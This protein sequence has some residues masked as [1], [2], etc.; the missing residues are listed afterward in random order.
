MIAKLGRSKHFA[1]A[2][3]IVIAIIVYGSLYPFAFRPAD[4]GIGPALR[5]LWESRADQPGRITFIG[6]ILLYMPLGFFAIDAL[7]R[8]GGAAGRMA[9]ITLLGVLL[10]LSMELLQYFDEGR[11]TDAPDV[12]ANTLG[13]L[14]GAAAGSLLTESIRWPFLSEIAVARV[15]TLLLVAWVGYRLFPFVPTLDLHKYWSALKPTIINPDPTYYDL[16]RYTA[17]WLGI[18]ALIE[19]IVDTRRGW[20]FFSLFIGGSLV[21][22][23]MIVDATLNAGEIA[24]A[25]AAIAAWIVL[26]F[27][28]ALRTTLIGLSFC[29]YVVAERLEPFQFA[30]TPGPFSWIPLRGFMSGDLAIDVMSFLQKFFL[31]GSLIW[32]LTQA[33]VPGDGG[34][35]WG[36]RGQRCEVVAALAGERQRGGQA[37]GRLETT[38]A[39]KRTGVAA[40]A[41][42][43]EAGS[44]LARRGGRTG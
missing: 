23:I 8:R 39:D 1:I 10:S 17:M 42:R 25:A 13:T 12:Y 19:A 6:N 37:D 15:P 40:G 36:E 3:T 22:K 43:R 26:G 2:T 16:L 27:R 32:L 7:G 33:G 29:A 28:P 30:A 41:D 24:G 31:Y 21:G 44:D 11:V 4:D 18:G 9:L 5:A 35:V 14:I 20:L 38:V 34:A